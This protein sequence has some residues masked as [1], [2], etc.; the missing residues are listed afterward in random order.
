MCILSQFSTIIDPLVLQLQDKCLIFHEG[1]S[2]MHEL[3]NFL[4]KITKQHYI[5]GN[6]FNQAVDIMSKLG[7]SNRMTLFMRD[8]RYVSVSLGYYD[9]LMKKY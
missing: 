8:A 7:R 5:W 4:D 1:I 6:I 2:K 3:I 9:T